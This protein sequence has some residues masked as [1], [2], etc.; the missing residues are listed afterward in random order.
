MMFVDL[1][2]YLP[3]DILVKVDRA[4]MRSRWRRAYRFSIIA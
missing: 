3:D 1:I 4:A 2:S